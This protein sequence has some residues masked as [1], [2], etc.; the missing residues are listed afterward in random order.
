MRLRDLDDRYLADVAAWFD[1]LVRRFT[2]RM[3]KPPPATGPLPV[4]LR[5]RALDDRWAGSGPLAVLREVPQVGAVLIAALVLGN[6]ATVRARAPHH[7]PP[8]A[9]ESP[10][11]SSELPDPALDDHL[12]PR[13]GEDVKAYIAAAKRHLDREGAGQPDASV[14]A[15][16]QLTEYR[17]PVQ[18]RELLGRIPVTR[19]LFRA[20]LRLPLGEAHESEVKDLVPDTRKAMAR[21]A[22]RREAEAHELLKVAAT[23]ENDPEQKADQEKDARLYQRE[24]AV[25]KGPCACVFAVVVR[26]PYRLLFDLAANPNVRVVDAGSPGVDES[27]Y[28]Y[29]GLLP[30]ETR[31]VTAGNQA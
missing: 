5:L 15:V 18:V 2:D 3:P 25:L 26:A 28:D 30:E 12:G 20:P 11:T 10:G 23:I 1:R 24:A 13:L 22:A 21:F 31:V 29:S 16:V 9:T 19:V 6:A 14:V 4:I 27:G 8:V 17:T 7:P